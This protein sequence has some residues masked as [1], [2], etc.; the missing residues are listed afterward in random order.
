MIMLLKRTVVWPDVAP[1]GHNPA[2]T[3]TRLYAHK[4]AFASKQI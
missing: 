4:P 2:L 3:I 1:V